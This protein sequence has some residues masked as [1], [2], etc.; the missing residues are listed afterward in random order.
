MWTVIYQWQFQW[1]IYDRVPCNPVVHV[2]HNKNNRF[3][4]INFES[5][6]VLNFTAW[7]KPIV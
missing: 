4:Y 6:S 5:V 3:R 1:Q 2:I 7:D